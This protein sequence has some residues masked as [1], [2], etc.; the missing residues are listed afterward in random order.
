MHVIT[1]RTLA[2]IFVLTGVAWEAEGTDPVKVVL[3]QINAAHQQN[4]ESL[5]RAPIRRWGE[6]NQLRP[7]NDL[8]HAL[9]HPQ[10]AAAAPSLATESA[11][12]RFDAIYREF[13][14]QLGLL[15]DG[16]YRFRPAGSKVVFPMTIECDAYVDV[17]T[18]LVLGVDAADCTEEIV[19]SPV[20]E[21]GLKIEGQTLTPAG[22]FS[23]YAV[24]PMIVTGE[25]GF[26]ETNLRVSCAGRETRLPLTVFIR[27]SGRLTGTIQLYDGPPRP[28]KQEDPGQ[29]TASEGHR[30]GSRARSQTAKLLVE[31]ADGRLYVAPGAPNYTTQNWYGTW[32]PRFTYVD[33]EFDLPVPPG[34]Y[35]V[36]AMKGPGY[37]DFVGEVTVRAGQ[38]AALPIRLKQLFPLE[39]QGWLCAD[40]HTHARRIPLTML[41]SEDV[42]VVTRTFYSSHKPYRTNI[43]KANSDAL[44]LSAENQEIEHWNAGNVFFFNI[45]T[46]VQDPGDR[47]VEMTP[48]FHYDHQAH[49]MGGITLRYMRARPFSPGGGGQA[50]PE[51]AVSAASGLMDVWTVMEN[52][53]QNLLGDPRNR[54][55][56]NGWPNDRIYANT[57]KNWY[58]LANCGLRIPVAA[59]T[60]Y[61]RLSRLGYNRVYAKLDGE[62]TTANW[63]KALLRGDGFVTNGPLLWLR[64]NDRLPGDGSALDSPGRA[65]VNVRLVSHQPVRLVEIL[66]NG[67]VVASRELTSDQNEQTM[68][69]EEVLTVDGP[70]WFAARCFGETDVRYPHQTAPNQFA[71][72]N[73]SMVIA[74]GKRP[75]SPADAAHFVKE[76]DALIE[77]APNIPSDSM[78]QRALKLYNEA[79]Q[80][81]TAQTGDRTKGGP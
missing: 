20:D 18:A 80:Y 66:Q 65:K 31:D 67:K 42:N 73:M 50:Q 3:D 46:S 53:M 40:M 60:S 72:T 11:V 24:L 8:L 4:Y 62:L 52:S 55:S 5:E 37:A 41:R 59:G 71:H 63:A 79:R 30:T 25:S 22:P 17:P 47:P 9:R 74:A 16:E 29:S 70:C 32:L 81:Y 27:P 2:S 48:M 10:S 12:V 76:I 7:L 35:R 49:A 61:G 13:V 34:E 43:D 1:L 6:L 56:G 36:T 19:I 51:L 39:Q 54:W 69:W 38:S 21:P 68:E 57:Y 45:P 44:H 14:V 23:L 26:R 33:G 75:S 15:A 77:F 78:R 28:S 64:V 58:A